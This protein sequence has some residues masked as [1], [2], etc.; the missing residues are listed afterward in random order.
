MII[1]SIRLKNIKSYGEGRDG[2][3]ITIPFEQ[4]INRVAGR[5]GHGKTT[6]IESIG[7]ALF[8][9]QPQFEE[10]FQK[11][12]Y[13]LRDGTKEG[14]I[15]VTF[16]CEG[17][18]YRVERAVGKQTKRRSKVIQISDGSICAE[19]EDEVAAFLCRLLKA[20]APQ[21][22]NEVFCKLVGVKQGRLTWPFDSKATESKRYFEPLLQVDVF[23]DC[24]ERL[25]E[26]V[27]TFKN[28][29]AEQQNQM[30]AIHERIRLREGSPKA[31][32]DAREKVET[33]AATL[34]TETQARETTLKAKEQWEALEK[35]VE[36]SSNAVNLATGAH[37]H[38]KE[39]RVAG[40]AQVTESKNSA[41]V[42][43]DNEAAKKAYEDAVQA[44]AKLDRERLQRDELKR[45]RDGAEQ[46]RG[47]HQA[48]S[49][50][51]TDQAKLLRSQIGK[52]ETE[53]ADLAGKMAP[54]KENLD[55]S[56]P[57]FQ[58]SSE[59]AETAEGHRDALGGWVNGLPGISKSQKR[60]ADTVERLSGEISKWDDTQ[61]QT[62]GNAE[63]DAAGVLK[64]A[65]D[66]L[67]KAEE[68]HAT[69]QQQLREITGGMCPFLKEKCRQFD[70][71]K[72][73][74]DLEGQR[75]ALVNLKA[76]VQQNNKAHQEVNVALGTLKSAHGKIAGKKTELGESI[77]RYREGLI[78]LV[79]DDAM[80]SLQWLAAWENQLPAAPV[81]PQASSK[82]ITPAG[83]AG[84][85]QRFEAFVGE[86]DAWWELAAGLIKARLKSFQEEAKAR[87]AK[88]STLDQMSEQLKG[89]R[90]EISGLGKNA[91]KKDAEASQHDVEIGNLTI[92]LAPLDEALKPFEN[93]DEDL[94]REQP[95]RDDN[96][97][98]YDRYIVAKTLADDLAPRHARLVEL[99]G[100]EKATQD[101][102]TKVTE[103]LK[104]AKHDFDPEKL[105]AARTEHQSKHDL[106]TRLTNTL[107]TEKKEL[108]KEEVRFDE[109][110]KA[111][112]ECARVSVEIGRC[113]AAVALT[114][115]A[116]KTLRDTAPA[117]AQH[118]CSRIAK[119]AQRVFNQ[120]NPDP[121]ELFWDAE[122]YSLRVAPGER[123]FAMLSGG[124]QTKL[125]LAMT[126]SMIED[127]SS[128]RFCIFDEPT[129]GVDAD[130]RHKLA[131]AILA[132]REAASLD[133]LLLV[134]HD[135]VF[136][137]KIEHA[138][139]LE[140]T[141]ALGTRVVV[142]Q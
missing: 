20:P 92:Q 31:L 75:L 127:F 15:D 76:E 129:Y 60:G 57:A 137:G 74:A 132:A 9:T 124:E 54:V 118:L 12:T 119:R 8:L 93:L 5:N 68:R 38:A 52:K 139:L 28:Q 81:A 105:S 67:A 86:A 78:S 21:Q 37:T 72:V 99:Q 142:T 98:G 50:A 80:D 2:N 96:R 25:K 121:I 3:G 16:S 43:K 134:S 138:I 100:T 32:V 46:K 95:K 27:D 128:L 11:E 101:A 73:R 113:D 6:L 88:E 66:E 97:A 40:E 35:A 64:L 108:K 79:S 48:K 120:I 4:G 85:Q 63:R 44:L 26:A 14:E 110:E 34:A 125:A 29:Q 71:A 55:A 91:A 10:N 17:D 104:K 56:A 107:E 24:F 22:L 18:S 89:F 51:A 30:A 126:L 42:I 84:F 58:K 131:D 111:C 90:N 123:R 19:G 36:N 87:R 115:L 82:S 102:L 70:P 49:V 135:D 23:R 45:Q 41:E 53:C 65:Q 13:F 61:M 106:V 33:I 47:D 130:S 94:K 7:F 133:Q 117:V 69:L 77:E 109:W 141:A 83:L 140:K 112:K 122:R 116:R 114:E 62:V 59:A 1:Q 103:A 136:E 39:L